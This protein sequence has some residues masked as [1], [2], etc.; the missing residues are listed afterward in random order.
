MPR[1]EA[2]TDA[3]TCATAA[4]PDLRADF[5]DGDSETVSVAVS[6]GDSTAVSGGDSTAVSIA[7]SIANSVA[8]SLMVVSLC[9]I[10]TLCPLRSGG[11]GREGYVP[12]S[13]C[14]RLARLAI[15]R[16]NSTLS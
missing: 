13:C 1:V 4:T 12:A 7:G 11:G 6:I 16:A 5:I 3:A 15:S 10:A 14:L 9:S 2:A 8:V